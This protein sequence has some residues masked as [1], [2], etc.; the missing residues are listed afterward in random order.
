[1][2][3][4]QGD[5]AYVLFGAV[6]VEG[7]AL[8]LAS[9]KGHKN[10]VKMLL[11]NRANVNAVGGLYKSNAVQLAFEKGHENIV[12]MLLAHGAVMPEGEI[13]SSESECE[14]DASE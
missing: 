9:L 8:Q 4:V 3:L 7:S 14:D 12:N 6:V 11:D 13:E 5:D 10:V 2:L 1:M